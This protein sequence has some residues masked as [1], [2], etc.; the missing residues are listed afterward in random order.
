[1]WTAANLRILASYSF[2]AKE[3][4]SLL[5]AYSAGPV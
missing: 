1:M 2:G 5:P 4:A 3:K